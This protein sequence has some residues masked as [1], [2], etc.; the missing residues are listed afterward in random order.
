MQKA[1][2]Q[3]LKDRAAHQEQEQERARELREAA[4]CGCQFDHEDP[5]FLNHPHAADHNRAFPTP[6]IEVH[7]LEVPAVAARAHTREP[8]RPSARTREVITNMPEHY[9]L[10][11]SG[12]LVARYVPEDTEAA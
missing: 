12:E 5:A 8:V 3:W 2:A 11:V 10:K 6:V 4:W 1:R 7:P 9:G